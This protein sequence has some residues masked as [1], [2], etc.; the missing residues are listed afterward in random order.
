MVLKFYNTLGR[1]K[2]VFKPI[3]KGQVNMYACGLT[4]YNY[5][6][7]GNYR[8]FVASDILRRYLE[9]S[10]YKVKKIVNITDVDDKTIKGSIKEGK[11]LK[12]FTKKYEDAFFEDEKS[13]NIK[14]ADKYPKATEHIK[15][16]VEIIEKLLKKDYAYKTDDGIYFNI[17]KFKDYGKLAKLKLDQLKEGARVDSDEYDKENAKDFALWKFYDNEDGDVFW[18][19][20]IG[21]G[22]PGWHIECSAMSTKYLGQPFDIHTGAV[23]LIFPHHENEIAQSE[24][25][26]NKKFVNYWIHNEWLMVNGKKMSKSLGN[27]YTLRDLENLNHPIIALRYLFLTS[28]YRSQLNF[29]LKNLKNA[30][31]SLKR[32]KRIIR[33]TKDDKKTNQKYINQFKKTMDDDLN[34]PEALQVLWKLVRDKKAQGKIN[35]IKEIDKVFGLDLFKSKKTIIPEDIQEL[36]DK[37]EKARKDKDWDKADKIR[38]KINKLGYQI[39]DTENGV[40]I[41]KVQ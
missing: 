13:L 34:T 24:A 20:K 35:T 1:E 32:L 16:M 41:S 6:H 9:Y 18:D 33:E 14:P 40:N 31:N 21:K 8:A 7:I 15:E 23:D 11:K 10:G 3:K 19:T 12:D 29:T 36:I 37:R 25:S 30:E 22:R 39:D 17:K 5:G 38:D 27:F 2:E 28:H 26:N 4:V